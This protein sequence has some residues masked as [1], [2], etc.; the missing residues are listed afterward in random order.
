M[1]IFEYKCEKCDRIV[2]KLLFGKEID[3]EQL[4]SKCRKPMKRIL[5]TYSFD[6]HGYNEKNGYSKKEPG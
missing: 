3:E 4:C 1:P 6:I 2:E 5:S